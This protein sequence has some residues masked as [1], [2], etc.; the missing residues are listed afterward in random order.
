VLCDQQKHHGLVQTVVALKE[1][2]T[3]LKSSSKGSGAKV[4]F[5]WPCQYYYYVIVVVVD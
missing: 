5:K 3:L 1:G 2:K 4:L